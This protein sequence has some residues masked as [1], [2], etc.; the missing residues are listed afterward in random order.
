MNAE[1]GSMLPLVAGLFALCGVLVIGIIDSTDLAIHRTRL[2]TNADAA[3]LVGAETY[4]PL[5]AI[6][7]GGRLDVSLDSAKVRAAVENFVGGLG[8]GILVASAGSADG[9]TAVVTLEQVW[10]PPLVSDFL[11]VAL[12]IGADASARAVFGE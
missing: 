3:A 1:R 6:F 2:Q 10:K 12:R 4:D 11:P 7:A 8:E 5:S 9:K